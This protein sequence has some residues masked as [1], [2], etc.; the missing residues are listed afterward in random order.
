MESPETKPTTELPKDVVESKTEKTEP[1][2]AELLSYTKKA[3]AFIE[4]YSKTGFFASFSGD[5]S[6]RF[7]LSNGFYFSF[8]TGEVNIDAKWFY[9]RGFS[10]RQV[11]WACMHEIAHFED[12]KKDPDRLLE[13]FD[14]ITDNARQTGE[15]MLGRWQ[16]VLD[17]NDPDQAKFFDSLKAESIVHPQKPEKGNWNSLARSSYEIHH[18]FYNCLD[19]IWVN[20]HVSRKAASFEKNTKGGKEVTDLYKEKLFPETNYTKQSRHRQFIYK[21]LRDD[22]VPEQECEVSADVTEALERKTSFAGKTYTAKEL[23]EAYVKPK[24]GRDTKAG[25]RYFVIQKTL[26]PIF[27]ELLMKDLEEWKPEY[28]AP[29][30]NQEKNPENTKDE[31]S[32]PSETPNE[33]EPQD[34]PSSEESQ[35]KTPFEDEIKEWDEKNMDQMPPDAME[36]IREKFEEIEQQKKEDE[37]KEAKQPKQPKEEKE[38]SPHEKAKETQQHQDTAWAEKNASRSHSKEEL[39]KSL[40]EF[41]DIESEIAPYLNELSELWRGIVFGS[42]RS[43]SRMLGGSYQTGVELDVQK[44]VDEWGTIKEG[45]MDSARI[46]KREESTEVVTNTPDLIRVRLLGDMSGSMENDTGEKLRTLR[47]VTALILSSLDEFNTYLN[48]TRSETKSKLR[49]ETEVRIFGDAEQKIKSFDDGENIETV[50]VFSHL[51]ETIGSTYDNQALGA[52]VE[53]ITPEDSEL[54]HRGKILDIV[55]EITDGG[56]DAPESARDAIHS[57][58]DKGAVVRAFQIGK[59]S[60]YEKKLFNIVWNQGGE[61]YGEI[62]TDISKLVPA[63]TQALKKYLGGVEI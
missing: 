37:A 23:I 60:E 11:L 51:N 32:N 18:A 56:S 39:L 31:S 17:L 29:Q 46:F 7:K 26:E 2:D 35:E 58:V 49:A 4:R 21:L 6:L 14:H 44:A 53:S 16:A 57:L 22:N 40:N 61:K 25:E 42:S 63:I 45:K 19:D 33:G 59:T 48:S 38:K 34:E 20:N 28:K 43:S 41:R 3:Q 10:E 24:T 27:K 55:F 9:E 36:E 12:F 62:V 47:Q 15:Y 50:S 1:S 8:D 5:A 52:V 30:K 54:M 13:N